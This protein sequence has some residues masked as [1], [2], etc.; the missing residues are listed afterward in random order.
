MFSTP[1]VATVLAGGTVVVPLLH[2]ARSH[3]PETNAVR[4]SLALCVVCFRYSLLG[5]T[6]N[7]ALAAHPELSARENFGS[8]S[9]MLAHSTKSG[10]GLF[11]SL[12]ILIQNGS[13]ISSSC[14]SVFFEGSKYEPVTRYLSTIMVLHYFVFPNKNSH[15]AH[16]SNARHFVE[17]TCRGAR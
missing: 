4:P 12:A 13:F 15:S 5:E 16:L 6:H 8:F 1:A 14:F 7:T 9:K 17:N 2:A 3:S 10:V 11:F